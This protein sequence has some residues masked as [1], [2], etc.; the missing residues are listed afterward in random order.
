MALFGQSKPSYLGIDFGG[1]GVKLVELMNEKG[2][3]WSTLKRS[4][5]S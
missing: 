3:A 2:R 1:G 4:V 5:P